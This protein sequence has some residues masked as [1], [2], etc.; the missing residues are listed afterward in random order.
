VR[1]SCYEEADCIEKI[2]NAKQETASS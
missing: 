1:S 2:V